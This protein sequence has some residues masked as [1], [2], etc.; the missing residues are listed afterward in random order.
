MQALIQ[1]LVRG[2]PTTN[3]V[4]MM[5]RNPQMK[6]YLGVIKSGNA[7]YNDK[8]Q[9]QNLATWTTTYNGLNNVRGQAPFQSQVNPIVMADINADF[10]SQLF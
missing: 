10:Y 1:S 6:T 5:Q 9:G 2:H 8:G 3:G 4:Q 7:V